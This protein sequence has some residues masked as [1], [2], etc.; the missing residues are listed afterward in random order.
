MKVSIEQYEAE[1]EDS[2]GHNSEAMGKCKELRASLTHPDLKLD[3]YSL[4]QQ[5]ENLESKTVE[6]RVLPPGP[7]RIKAQNLFKRHMA[8]QKK[9]IIDSLTLL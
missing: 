1:I 6:P 2:M 5:T 7:T 4:D 3:N 8:E 9:T